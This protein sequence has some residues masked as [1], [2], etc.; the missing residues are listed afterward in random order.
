[1]LLLSKKAEDK[2]VRRLLLVDVFR[3]S[4]TAY[5]SPAT[6]EFDISRMLSS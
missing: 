3:R 6:L 5:N 4:F 1:M 2:D